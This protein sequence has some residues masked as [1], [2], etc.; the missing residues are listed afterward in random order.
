MT[1]AEVSHRGSERARMMESLGCLWRSRYLSSAI[2]VG[3]R[4]G[5][6]DLTA[7]YGSE[8]L[9]LNTRER[10]RVEVFDMK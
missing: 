10:G 3:I 2:K 8:S 9:V 7:L 6:L 4:E 1:E 5:I